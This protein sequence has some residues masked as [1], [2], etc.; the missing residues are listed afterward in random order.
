M[1]FRL[2][3]LLPIALLP[4]LALLLG[5]EFLPY[6]LMPALMLAPA[7]LGGGDGPGSEGPDGDDG[8]GGGGGRGPGNPPG[9]RPV[10]PRGGLPLPDAEPGRVRLR[11][12]DRRLGARPSHRRRG[13]PEPLRGP[14]RTPCRHR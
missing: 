8:G 9:P 12:H 7:L 13:A 5:L 6:L 1:P 4:G 14:I 11:S 3:W 10:S 2:V